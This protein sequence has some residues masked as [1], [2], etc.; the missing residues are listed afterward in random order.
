MP[1]PFAELHPLL[2]ARLGVADG[3]RGPADH[4]ARARSPSRRA[5]P[6]AIRPDTVFMPF[7]WGG[8][9]SVNRLT[10]D[11][12]DPVSGMPEFK[13]CAVDVTAARIRA[14]GPRRSHPRHGG[15]A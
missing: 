4:G 6:T 15:R 5:S 13:V 2:A 8:A 14:G 7:H 12:T 3:E 9:G 10:T 1:E 11:A